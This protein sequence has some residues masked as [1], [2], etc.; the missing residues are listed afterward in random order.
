MTYGVRSIG[1]GVPVTSDRPPCSY[2]SPVFETGDPAR[3]ASL[4]RHSSAGGGLSMAVTVTPPPMSLGTYFVTAA[5][6]NTG[7]RA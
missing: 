2:H 4:D 5:L 7:V 3:S 6:L 1:E